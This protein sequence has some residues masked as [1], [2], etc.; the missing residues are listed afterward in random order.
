MPG[1]KTIAINMYCLVNDW[2][3]WY[4]M[5]PAPEVNAPIALP[6]AATATTSRGGQCPDVSLAHTI[7]LACSQL[8]TNPGPNWA[9]AD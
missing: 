6:P 7:Y 5:P 2:T 8:N 1:V 9:G 4:E 3:I